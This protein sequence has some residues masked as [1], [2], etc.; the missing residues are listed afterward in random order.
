MSHP[1]LGP[2]YF[3]LVSI[4][5]YDGTQT[6]LG[7][8]KDLDAVFHRLRSFPT[9]CGDEYHIECFHL[10]D[11]HTECARADEVLDSRTKAKAEFDAKDKV[12]QEYLDRNK[13]SEEKAIQEDIKLDKK[14]AQLDALDDEWEYQRSDV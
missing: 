8:F 11:K 3:T 1:N 12:Y 9:S 7:I 4:C 2:E 6:V 13:R 5:Q 10:S 14:Y